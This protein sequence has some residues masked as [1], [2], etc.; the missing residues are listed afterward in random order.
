VIGGYGGAAIDSIDR[1][2]N[3]EDEEWESLELRG[4]RYWP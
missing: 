3:Y 2:V 1:E 4:I